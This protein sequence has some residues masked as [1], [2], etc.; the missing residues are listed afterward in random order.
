MGGLVGSL[1]DSEDGDAKGSGASGRVA[2]KLSAVEIV[3][4]VRTVVPALGTR[5]AWVGAGGGSDGESHCIVSNLVTYT[6]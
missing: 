5:R 2:P 6:R 3:G 1:S 4:V